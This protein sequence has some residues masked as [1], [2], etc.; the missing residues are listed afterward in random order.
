MTAVPDPGS[1][2][3][4]EGSSGAFAPWTLARRG[5][6]LFASAAG[7]R[8]FR[9]ATDV[10]LLVTALVLLAVLV[11]LYPPGPFERSVIRM[12]AAA[13][14]WL[15]PL[16]GFLYDMTLLWAAAL[17]TTLALARRGQALLQA[18]VALAIAVALSF[19][20]ARLAIGH[21]PDLLASL[22]RRS[23][24]ASFPGVRV[25]LVAA[26]VLTISPNLVQRLQRL[27]RYVTALG[28]G[29]ALLLGEGTP[30]G[31]LAG[32]AIA[33][34]AAAAVRL[35]FGTSAGRPRAA[36]V[37]TAL[38]ELGVQV[39]G[40]RLSDR[41]VA[42]V[43]A[44]QGLDSGGTALTVKVLG[45]DAYD[46]QLLERL[47][48]FLWY[49][50]PRLSVRLSRGQIAEHE[51][52]M[53]LLARTNA[54]P[55]YDVLR[56][57]TAPDDTA[58]LALRGDVR[59]LASL[60][61]AELD[62]GLP[63][64]LWAALER[65]VGAN[66]AHSHI[67]PDTVALVDGEAGFV[68]F[69][70]ATSSPTADQLLTDEAQLL[71]ATATRI[72]GEAA[73]RAAVTA[74]GAGGVERLLPYLQSAALEGPLRR[75]AAA[76]AIDVDALRAEAAS[77]V[78][79][80]ELQLVRLRRVTWSSAVQT[81]LLLL[82]ALAVLS[83]ATGIDYDQFSD[84]LG[85]ATWGWNVLGLFAAQTPRLTQAVSTLGSVAANLR[86]GPVYAMQLATSYMNLA[87]PSVFARLAVNIRFFQRQGVPPAAAVTAGGIDSVT[88]TVI[89][90]VLL[91]LL[92]VFS[93]SQLHLELSAPSGGLLT[94][95]WILVGV[96]VVSVAGVFLIGRVRRLLLDRV[97]T[98]WPQVRTAFATLR[99]S[100]KLFLLVFGSLATE[101]LFAVTLGIFALGFGTRIGLTD[102]LVINISV[103]LFSSL[104]P[105]P[106]G[107]GVTEL[108]LTVGLTSAGMTEATALGAVL[109]YRIATFYLPPVWGVFALRW[110]QRNKYL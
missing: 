23:G 102:L 83:F 92:L 21:T 70:G 38:A 17:I 3:R 58:V 12:L 18:L 106:G 105:V 71:V 6:R 91:V 5:L 86:F 108:G 1:E 15:D 68:D 48:R 32:L 60:D 87:L 31:E 42:G 50:E 51:A 54:V 69:G 47:W 99:S 65:L 74:L 64:R 30:S 84:A 82:A 27:N 20:A 10:I 46:N 81:A 101:L 75:A 61:P 78:G 67:D 56:V 24:D 14:H 93:E 16:W 9:R 25:A 73:L 55:T 43:V 98:W 62:D 59:P 77:L 34:V 89:Q 36:D 2:T 19:A 85:S 39:D 110:L 40:L 33:V 90:A 35:A 72:G 95:L 107:I 44:F 104:I 11:V 79:A 53:T 8:R 45:R 49:P 97:R 7:E 22:R 109:L 57:A 63:A 13:P 28:F 100:N 96:L 80:E 94:V 66:I 26:V 41:Q 88:S 4:L 29:S 52:L 103:A 76:A 37:E